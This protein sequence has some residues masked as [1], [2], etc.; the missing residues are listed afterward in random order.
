MPEI[1]ANTEFQTKSS[2][3]RKTTYRTGA[4]RLSWGEGVLPPQESKKENKNKKSFRVSVQKT[5]E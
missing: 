1:K 4:G 5:E 3:R 2:L